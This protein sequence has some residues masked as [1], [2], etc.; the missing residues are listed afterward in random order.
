M[1]RFE[2]IQTYLTGIDSDGCLFLSLCSIAEEVNGDK[3][4]FLE[5]V[6]IARENK[7][8]SGNFFVEDSCSLLSVLTG[9]SWKRTIVKNLPPVI[10]EKEYT[11]VKLRQPSGKGF[12]FKRRSFDTLINSASTKKNDIAEYY[13]YRWC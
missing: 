6:R 1:K 5:A 3:I 12:H 8:V 13:I 10:D 7:L 4:D 2:G 9:K 11:I